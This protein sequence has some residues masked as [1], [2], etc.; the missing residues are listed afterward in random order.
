MFSFLK[1]RE[2]RHQERAAKQ[3][4]IEAYRLGQEGGQAMTA[5]IDAFLT[6]RLAQLRTNLFD[7]FA[8]R[9]LT[10]KDCPEHS[11]QLVARA[12]FRIFFENTER[13]AERMLQETQEAVADWY[14]FAEELGFASSFKDYVQS[15]AENARLEMTMCAIEM[16][17]DAIIAADPHANRPDFSDFAPNG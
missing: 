10:I 14:K 3:R 7:V 15:K 9:L 13:L 6:P 5:A 8:Q 17:G 1:N 16:A 11:P 4:R 12:E 2:R